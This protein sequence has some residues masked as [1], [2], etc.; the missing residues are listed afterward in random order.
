MGASDYAFLTRWRIEGNIREIAEVL[1][2]ATALPR[3]WPAVYLEVKELEPGGDNGLG[4]RIELYTKGWLPYTLRWRFVIT[5]SDPPHGFT[6][7]AEGDLVGTGVWTLKQDGM[8]VDV[9]Y[10]WRIRADKALLRYMSFLM[11][12][13]F[14]ANHRWAMWM[15]EESLK[16]EL[17][18]RE[19]KT[20]EERARVAPPPEP[21]PSSSVA[22]IRHLPRLLGGMSG[23]PAKRA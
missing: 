7:A 13:M 12:P 14:A 11:K 22:F 15:G 19:A 9:A 20:P 10:D 5:Q 1:G 18:R 4:R 23:G 16:L 17:A 2:E 21:T 6:L 3:W 8:M